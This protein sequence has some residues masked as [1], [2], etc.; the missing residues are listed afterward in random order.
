MIP[1]PDPIPRENVERFVDHMPAELRH[2]T[3]EE[4]INL[5]HRKLRLK[6]WLHDMGVEPTK[7]SRRA[8]AEKMRTAYHDR[9]RKRNAGE[10]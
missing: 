1:Y 4:A 5:W 9:I 8:Y 2:I 6:R 10:Q 3:R 7:E